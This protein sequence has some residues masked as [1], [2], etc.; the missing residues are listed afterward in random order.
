MVAQS[1]VDLKLPNDDEDDIDDED[2]DDDDDD[3]DDNGGDDDDDNGD[4]V[5]LF[6][7]HMRMTNMVRTIASSPVKPSGFLMIIFFLIII[8]ITQKNY[9]TS[10]KL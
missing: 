3:D 4:D 9:I 6:S 10:I 2:D 7:I 1:V 8:N 5:H